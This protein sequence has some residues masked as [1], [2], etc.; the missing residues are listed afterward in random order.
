M[1]W[2]R[3]NKEVLFY[4]S[5]LACFIAVI[6]VMAMFNGDKETTKTVIVTNQQCGEISHDEVKMYLK[7]INIKFPEI[8]YA[9]TV[10]ETG[11]YK[12]SICYENN[13]LCGMKISTKRPTVAIG[14]R[15]GYALYKTWQ[16][17]IIDYALY[18]AYYFDDVKTVEEY[19]DSLSNYA[20]DSSYIAKIKVIAK[21]F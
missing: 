18:Q 7:Q 4:L 19:L 14:S 13:N 10:L 15:N 11:N 8:V 2:L 21:Q 17:S 20:E 1:R 3:I 5:M 9:Q 12:S 16:E 6:F